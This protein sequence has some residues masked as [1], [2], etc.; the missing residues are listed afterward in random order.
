MG[1]GTHIQVEFD[2]VLCLYTRMS[3]TYVVVVRRWV[4][5]DWHLCTSLCITILQV[6][7][8]V[9]HYVWI[10]FATHEPIH[11]HTQSPEQVC[12]VRKLVSSHTRCTYVHRQ[13]DFSVWRDPFWKQQMDTIELNAFK[14]DSRFVWWS[15]PTW[16]CSAEGNNKTTLNKLQASCSMFMCSC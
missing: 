1:H 3:T 6:H 16:V 5:R 9:I 2:V 12:A 13:W 15:L 7:Q 4:E 14:R 10:Y 8:Y 11:S